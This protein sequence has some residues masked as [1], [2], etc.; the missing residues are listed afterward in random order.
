ME[1][2]LGQNARN[3]GGLLPRKLNPHPFADDL[4]EF[5]KLRSLTFK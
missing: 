4:G 5:K 3:S 1:A 2:K